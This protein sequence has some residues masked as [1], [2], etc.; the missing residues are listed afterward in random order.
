MYRCIF[1]LSVRLFGCLF[2]FVCFCLFLSVFVC[3]CLF[4]LF[5]SFFVCFCLLWSVF[6]CFCL[7]LSPWFRSCGVNSLF[8]LFSKQILHRHEIN[9]SYIAKNP[10]VLY[11]CATCSELPSNISTMNTMNITFPDIRMVVLYPP[12]F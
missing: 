4:C 1:L 9:I 7:F 6:V 12:D 8:L 11:V 3:F 2:V 5:L 10:F